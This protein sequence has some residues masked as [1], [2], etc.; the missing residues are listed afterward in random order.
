MG[1]ASSATRHWQDE[2]DVLLSFL[3]GLVRDRQVVFASSPYATCLRFYDLCLAYEVKSAQELK[4]KLGTNYTT[5]LVAK[6]KEEAILFARRLQTPTHPFVLNPTAFTAD[7]RNTEKTWSQKEYSAFW[8]LVIEKH[9]RTLYFNQG[10]QFSNSCTLAY[11]SGLRVGA[12]QFDHG[13]NLLS[14]DAAK[15]YVR[16]AVINLEDLGFDVPVLQAA[17]QEIRSFANVG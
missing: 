6:N 2:A 7:P 8:D 5:D 16:A 13:G 9:C 1:D 11:V 15:K 10:W 12:K 14:L 17:L 3:G 4:E